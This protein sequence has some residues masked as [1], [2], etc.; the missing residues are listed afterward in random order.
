M[1]FNLPPNF[2][3][4]KNIKLLNKYKDRIKENIK[5]NN[6]KIRVVKNV[7]KELNNTLEKNEKKMKK[8]MMNNKLK[9]RF[10]CI[11]CCIKTLTKEELDKHYCFFRYHRGCN[12][13]YDHLLHEVLKE[14]HSIEYDIINKSRD[15]KDTEVSNE[16]FKI[17]LI[18]TLTI[19]KEISLICQNCK[20]NNG[21]VK[22]CECSFNHIL[23]SLC[24][25]DS[26]KCPLCLEILNYVICPICMEER[27]HIID[28]NC[29]N[30]HR[31]CKRCINTILNTNPK[32]PFCREHIK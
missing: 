31:I 9:K 22:D 17:L 30:N 23:C 24:I 19:I 11:K 2:Q 25:K 5:S 13:I 27:K 16:S 4:I 15:I 32:C 3:Q 10:V 28:V 1:D 21:C 6:S 20:K 26:N 12:I 8:M 7:I 29:G 18:E 14:N